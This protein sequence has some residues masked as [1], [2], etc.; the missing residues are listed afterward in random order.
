[1]RLDDLEDA[2]SEHWKR[3]DAT[4]ERSKP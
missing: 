1:M 4:G 3:L 2:L